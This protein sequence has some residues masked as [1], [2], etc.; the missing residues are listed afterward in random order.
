VTEKYVVEALGQRGDGIV[1]DGTQVLH[2]PRT[3]P[4]ETIELIQGQLARIVTPSKDRTEPF[5][6]HFATCGGCKVQH[7][8]EPAY[9]E[10]KRRLLVEA[11]RRQGISG[12][13]ADLI[14]AHGAGRRRVVFHVREI[15]GTWRAGFMQA[16]SHHLT[17]VNICHVL[18]A[19]LQGAARIAA[20]FGPV[21]G[22]CD[23]AMTAASNGID[24]AVK[25]ERSAVDR[26]LQVLKTL[27]VEHKLLRLSVN[28]ETLFALTAPVVQF[29]SVT[30]RSPISAFL[31]ATAAGETLLSDLA[32]AALRKSRRI[33]DLFCGLGPFTFRLAQGAS[34]HSVDSEKP[35]IA[36]LQEA[37]RMVQGIKPVTTEA[38]DLFRNPLVPQELNAYDG[39]VL[40]PP[41]AGAEDQCR[42]LAK[43]KSKRLVY[44][45]CDVTSFARDAK[46]LINGGYQL[47]SVVPVDQ[48]KWTAHLETVGVFER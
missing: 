42:H 28:N 16:K 3:L 47:K 17:P 23:V 20:A 40:D 37:V 36:A 45:A 22:A 7:C 39:V 34:V 35:A 13:V 9:S 29:G 18:V 11:L 30:V 48:F 12:D 10:W 46:L 4:G 21:L 24:V 15:E 44:I 43:A 31:Q 41:R 1:H 6:E 19:E 27:F 5:C 38:R 33:A 26:R 8:A 25:A 2:I 14:D 32:V